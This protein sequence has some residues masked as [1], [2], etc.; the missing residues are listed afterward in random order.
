MKSIYLCELI[1]HECCIVSNDRRWLNL[2]YTNF[3]TGSA[4]HL[5]TLDK[6]AKE[7]TK[8]DKLQEWE[9]ELLAYYKLIDQGVADFEDET[10]RLVKIVHKNRDRQVHVYK[11]NLEY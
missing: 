10:D 11:C 3:Y 4:H 9:D 7:I 1:H 5:L 8:L 6:L 2:C